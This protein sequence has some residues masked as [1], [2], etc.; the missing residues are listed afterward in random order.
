VIPKRGKPKSRNQADRK[1]DSEPISLVRGC[2]LS[3]HQ[4]QTKSACES[5]AIEADPGKRAVRNLRGEMETGQKCTRAFSLP[6]RSPINRA[7]NSFPGSPVSFSPGNE[8][9]HIFTQKSRQ[10]PIKILVSSGK[11]LLQQNRPVCEISRTCKKESG[12]WD[13]ADSIS[14]R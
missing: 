13:N 1:W 2:P 12:H 14:A 5:L 10:Q 7:P 4:T 9:P 11:A 8:V 3:A 6:D